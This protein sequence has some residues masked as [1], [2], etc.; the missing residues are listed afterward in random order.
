[1]KNFNIEDSS[2]SIKK[3]VLLFSSGMDSF[4]IN[5]LEEPDILLFIDNKSKYSEVER[6]FLQKRKI[7]KLVF[8]NDIVNHSGIEMSNQI[9]PA[10]NMYFIVIASYF[11]D[12][13]ILGAT[14][15]DRST[16]K[17]KVFATSI[18]SL[19]N[20]IYSPSHWCEGRNISVNFKYKD[21]TKED[22]V[23]LYIEKR[24]F[25]GV[26]VQQAVEE[27]V[28][29]SFS[30]YHPINNI[31]CNRCKPDLRK[32]LAILGATGID[33]SS[34]YE[35][36]NRPI[37]YFTKERIESWINEL[38]MSNDRG[39]ESVQTINTLKKL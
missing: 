7:D 24:S 10:R 26:D 9:I 39:M 5:E 16:D 38:S 28:M 14:A 4:I 33:I 11:G 20:H 1:M 29:D 22:L 18:E 25:V 15:G 30:C 36:Y 13:I 37:D 35:E 12:N 8:F 27:L 32:F 2:S 34:Y 31:Q 3:K 23:R 17:D 6:N 19:L 21:Y